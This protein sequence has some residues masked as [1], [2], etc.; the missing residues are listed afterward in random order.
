MIHPSEVSAV[1][2]TRGNVP[3]LM[4]RIVRSIKR[5]GITDIVTWDNSQRPIDLSCYGRYEGIKEARNEFIYHQDDDLIAPVAQI[6]EAFDPV[7]DCRT[8]V[9]N[10]NPDEEWRLTNRGIIFH[11]SLAE[12][13]DA[14]TAL[15]GFDADFCRVS[16]VV[17]AYQH[18]FRRVTLGYKDLPNAS[19]H[20]SSMYL[21]HDHYEVRERARARTLALPVE[22]AA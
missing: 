10:D 22:V 12:C 9:A 2:V 7:Q 14:Y 16:D 5:A 21:D 15:Y 1:L 11:R 3:D 18:D 6:L 17:F 8:I 13:F 19:V 4:V 20:G